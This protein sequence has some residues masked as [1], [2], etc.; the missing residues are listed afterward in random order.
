MPLNRGKMKNRWTRIG[1]LVP[2][3]LAVLCGFGGAYLFYEY[4]A[5]P[6]PASIRVTPDFPLLNAR[7]VDP[8]RTFFMG[9]GTRLSEFGKIQNES[10]LLSYI[11]LYGINFRGNL[12]ITYVKTGRDG[13]LYSFHAEISPKF[14]NPYRGAKVQIEDGAFVVVP[15]RPFRDLALALLL[16]FVG[17]VAFT[18]WGTSRKVP[19]A[20]ERLP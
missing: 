1:L 18:V 7:R 5:T 4:F 8:D 12:E 14:P 20:Q 10:G 17:I 6:V 13:M 9:T 2:I 3:T 16:W 11:T 19:A 15:G